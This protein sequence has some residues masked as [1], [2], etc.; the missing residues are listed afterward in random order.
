MLHIPVFKALVSRENCIAAHI[1]AFTTVHAVCTLWDLQQALITE[2]GV[3][4]YEA[5]PAAPRCA[6]LRPAARPPAPE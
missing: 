3:P 4:A 2:E 5:S 6:S 1:N